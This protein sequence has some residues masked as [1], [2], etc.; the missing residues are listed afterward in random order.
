MD[1][2]Y[3]KLSIKKEWNVK[4]PLAIIHRA[5]E[6]LYEN[7]KIAQSIFTKMHR[8]KLGGLSNFPA[9]I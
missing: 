1:L 5:G 6:L 3:W 7:L 4:S 2:F 8:I 9:D